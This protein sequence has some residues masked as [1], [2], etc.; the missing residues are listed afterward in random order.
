MIKNLFGVSV[1]LLTGVGSANAS[2]S[3]AFGSEGSI[4]FAAHNVFTWQA[5]GDKGIWI[6]AVGG[7]WYYGTFNFP[8]QG[9]QFR[10]GVGFKYG[11]QG[12]LDKW[13]EV[14]VRR[15]SAPCLFKSFLVS[16]GPPSSKNA[17]PHAATPSSSAP[18]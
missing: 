2:N 7:T 11:P 14:H 5:D 9:L 17:A 6:Q 13:T 12:E 8:C 18:T 3:P 4:P 10:D 16:P 15:N 1:M